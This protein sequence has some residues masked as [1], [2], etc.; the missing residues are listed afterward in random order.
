MSLVSNIVFDS[1]LSMCHHSQKVYTCSE[2]FSYLSCGVCH[3][4]FVISSSDSCPWFFVC[5]ES[6][7][8]GLYLNFSFLSVCTIGANGHLLMHSSRHQTR[9]HHNHLHF[10]ILLHRFHRRP[11]IGCFGRRNSLQ[12]EPEWRQ[13]LRRRP[14]LYQSR[15]LQ[16]H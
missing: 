12:L 14:L 16:R 10:H 6:I 11:H 3:Q 1:L 15:C 7:V 2:I 4:S 9:S 5:P 13:E 8:L